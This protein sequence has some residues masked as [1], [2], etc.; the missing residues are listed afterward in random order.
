MAL[1]KVKGHIIADD[2]ALGGNPT[3]STQSASDNSTKI[4]T[5]AYVTTAVSNLVD[6]APSTL[7]TLNEI[8]AALNDDAALNTTLTN[9]IATKLPLAGGTLT[10]HLTI[11]DDIRLKFGANSDMQI[12]H[13]NSNGR[14]YISSTDTEIS[15]NSFRL[16]NQAGTTGMMTATASAISLLQP[17]TITNSLTLQ[18]DFSSGVAITLNR[19][20]SGLVDTNF[21]IGV[22]SSGS[23]A[24]DRMWLGTA[25][26]DLTITDAGNVGIGLANPDGF[27][28]DGNN[29]VIGT[30]SGDN[31]LSIISGTSNSSSIYF[32]D[33]EETG[34]GSRRGQVVYN[35]S[36][37]SMRIFAASAER[38]R[39]LST[40]NLEFKST[41]STFTGA[42]SFTNHTN[43][44]LYL[45]GGTSG[46]RLDDDSSINTIQ[47]VDGSSGYIKFETGDGT[48]RMRITSTGNVGIGVTNPA[49]GQL[50]IGDFTDATETLTFA[51]SNNGNAYINFY[52]NNATEGMFI[53]TTGQNYGGNLII[54]AKWDTEETEFTFTA[55]KT[56]TS[57][58]VI[59]NGGDF[60]NANGDLNIHAT[61]D[62]LVLTAED[63]VFIQSGNGSSVKTVTLANNGQT[64][65]PDDV[66]PTADNSFDLGATALRW[67]N[68]YTGDLH[69]SNE[70]SQNDVDGTSGN[71]T[72]QE[73]E[74]HLF[75]INN[76]TGK[77]YKFALEEIE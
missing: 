6:G 1:T 32:G 70:G 13:V 56:G 66:L 36:D 41:T 73:G 27:S 68:I 15:T 39:I 10:G 52:D 35:H 55:L 18:D 51:T 31:G 45:K 34:S 58:F 75:I 37:D 28:G 53:K 61:S 44:Y 3:T 49:Y 7:N 59:N 22:T 38:L 67:R 71:W 2:L 24:N 42:S 33:V 64:S 74:E 63:D 12:F 40:G 48:E 26:N 23:A 14:N 11:A 29:L 76:N 69:L 46:L 19:T 43:G 21:H 25:T 8:A 72:I 54:G 77:K 65:F 50:Q 30:T 5:T 17:T 4:A 20:E 60:T 62:D 9:S 47:I 16:F 57:S